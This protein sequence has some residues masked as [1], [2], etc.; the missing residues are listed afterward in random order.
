MPKFTDHAEM[1]AALVKPGEAIIQSLTPLKAHLWHMT[2]CV[3]GEVAELVQASIAD[4]NENF[5][6]ELGDIE[7]YL[8]GIRAPLHITRFQDDSAAVNFGLRHLTIEAANLFDAVKKHVIYN[9][10][11]D[12]KAIE[13]A[14][15]GIENCLNSVRHHSEITREETIQSNLDKLNKRYANGYSDKAAQERADKAGDNAA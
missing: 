9:K 4:D 15:A 13:T 14:L 6:E 11:L 8:E 7:F 1:V 10:E 12:I 2:S 5:V 3:M